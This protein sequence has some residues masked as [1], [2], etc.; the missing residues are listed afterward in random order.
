[1][2]EPFEP[3]DTT[4]LPAAN[5]RSKQGQLRIRAE[6]VSGTAE[7]VDDAAR[8]S[9]AIAGRMRIRADV[10]LVP[11]DSMPRTE[12]GKLKRVYEK[13]DDTPDLTNFT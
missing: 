5:K 1:M 13:V 4:G 6:A 11:E 7:L 3:V 9:K 12:V 10:E 8:I 2:P